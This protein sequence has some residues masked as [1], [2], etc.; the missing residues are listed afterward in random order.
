MAQNGKQTTLIYGSVTPGA[1]PNPDKLVTNSSGVELALNAADGKL[2]FKTPTGEVKLLADVNAV[3]GHGTAAITG[4]LID[5]ANIGSLYPATGKF[6]NLEAQNFRL[7]SVSGLLKS[8]AFGVE[9]AVL[10]TDYIDGSTLGLPGGLATLDASGKVVLS[11]L[12]NSMIN[13][14]EYLG[15]WDA[16]TNTPPIASG[17]G[18]TGQ[19]YKVRIPGTTNIDGQS[20]WD[21]GDQVVFNGT[22]WERIS[23]GSA[24]VS[25]VNGMT[26]AVTITRTHLGAAGAGVNTDITALTALTSQIQV[27]HGGTGRTTLSG[28]LKGSGTA[29][30]ETAVPF[31]DYLPPTTGT[32]TQLLANN[33]SGG[34]SNIT[35]GAGLQLVSGTL[36]AINSGGG[37]SGSDSVTY[38]QVSGGVT[39]MTFIGGPIT[40]SGTLTM[41]GTLSVANGGT[42][43][44]M[45][46]GMLKGNG[47][48]QIQTAVAGTDY[49]LPP[50]GSAGTIVGSDGAGGFT[51]IGVGSGLALTAGIL[52]ATSSGGGNGTVTSVAASGGTTGLTFS[53]SPITS[54]GTLTLGG[55]LSVPAGGTGAS[56]L[57]GILKGNGTAAIGAAVANLDYA[58]P[59]TG[60]ATQLLAN[61]GSRGFTNVTIGPGLSYSAGTLS[62][63]GVGTVSKVQLIGGIT[64]LKFLNDKV[65][66]SGAITLDGVLGV[67][68]GGTGATHINGLVKSNG[69]GPM[70]AAV[71]GVDYAMPPNG[72][73]GYVVI[74]DGRGGLASARLGAGLGYDSKGYL[75]V[76]LATTI[77]DNS[78]MDAKIA[79]TAGI[80]SSK[81]SFTKTGTG[82]VARPVSARL[83]DMLS[84]KD[85]GAIGDGAANDTSAIVAAI[86]AAKAVN[87]AVYFPA[88]TYLVSSFPSQNGRVMLY[89]NGDA[90]IKGGFNY[91]EAAFPISADTSTALTPNAPYFSA[92][93]LNFEGVGSVYGL[94]LTS[95][96]QAGFLSTFSLSDCRFFGNYGLK[97]THMIGFEMDHVEFNNAIVGSIF[98]G[99]VN[100]LFIKCRWQN[101]AYVGTHI[102]HAA[103]HGVNS[104]DR[105]GGENLKFVGCE[106]C[107]CTYG[108]IA[109]KHM[110]L[111]MDS[112]LMDYCS[113]PLKL[114]GTRYVK[115]SNSYLGAAVVA[116][117]RFASVPG[118]VGPTSTGIAIHGAPGG[119]TFGTHSTMVT[120]HNCEFINY[121][122][123]STQP[124]VSITGYANVTYPM[125]AGPCA[126]I[127]CLFYQP[128]QPST[129][130]HSATTLL[131]LSNTNGVRVALNRFVSVD[132]STTLNSAWRAD[133]CTEVQGFGNVFNSTQGGVTIRSPNETNLTQVYVQG[134]D[135]GSVPAGSIWVTP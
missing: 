46:S 128:F 125:S 100:G 68:N 132:C 58:V 121:V 116:N 53:G 14:L 81:L 95:I 61:N 114:V 51:Q 115:M 76:N 94:N 129:S 10:G 19:F 119:Y 79:T 25:S 85:F 82:A 80:Q 124:I 35:L 123:G 122:Q 135:P 86:A 93:G 133:N 50:T 47:N 26:G 67:A 103:D 74:N 126:F 56:T 6:T 42:G 104:F 130:G 8:T 21:V 24:L 72:G 63:T 37:G 22:V 113:V 97:C 65:T 71:P 27:S 4:G 49:A 17:I 57:S 62:T 64:G 15:S 36:S 69:A 127:D 91:H 45:L 66:T 43:R 112:C 99:C 111:V 75:A 96:E 32:A 38:V 12:P 101:Q 9:A 7:A 108:M 60:T 1:V 77:P 102:T 55:R 70:T 3:T 107:V 90:T 2:F 73:P 131:S 109:D 34:L 83:N 98:E 28:I 84:V 40:S 110:W 48:S 18:S 13:G 105:G 52:T 59:P 120:A 29:P 30:I 31:V 92:K 88:G 33:G 106:W 89:G 5:G 20:V 78:I 44:S 11:Q 39:G 16:S 41:T 117:A 118:Y 134:T 87:T 54:S 23:E